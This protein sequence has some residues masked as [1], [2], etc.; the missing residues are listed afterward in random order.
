MIKN[1]LKLLLLLSLPVGVFAQGLAHTRVDQTVGASCVGPALGLQYNVDNG[2]IF[3][4]VN[5]G[6][7]ASPVFQWAQ[8]P[9]QGNTQ[10]F[11]GTA[12]PGSVSGN[13][14]GAL[15]SDTTNHNAYVCNA[16]SGTAAPACTAVGAGNWLLLNSG[17]GALEV[18]LAGTAQGTRGKLNFT[19]TGTG[20]TQSCVDNSG[21]SRVDCS[22]SVDPA[23]TATVTSLAQGDLT[24][25]ISS[26]GTPA[27]VG[28][29]A[30]GC[31]AMVLKTG[32]TITL[33]VD[34]TNI[35]G[36]AS[37]N[38][39]STSAV[40][41]KTRA[42]ADPYPNV[43][44][45]NIGFTLYYNGVNWILPD[46]IAYGVPPEPWVVGTGGVIANTLVILDSSN[47]AK[48]IAATG[49]GAYGVAVS[50]V[51]A[52]G[53]V[54]VRRY[55][56]ASLIADTGGVTASHLIGA[57]TSTV[58]DGVDLAQTASS[59]V[60]MATRI[61]GTALTTATAGNPFYVSLTPAH[62]GTQIASAFSTLTDGATVTWAIGNSSAANQTLTFTTHG[63]SRTLNITN[64]VSGGN[65]VLKIIQD[66]TGVEGLT[67]GTGC[68]WKVIGGGAGAITTSTG[69]NAVDILAFTYDGAT[70]YATFGK[71]YN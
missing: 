48:V 18:D 58:I 11:F 30:A 3:A 39:C 5:N 27:Y 35:S 71:N 10:E 16:A 40:N 14:P 4:C 59:S 2:H 67:L 21:A 54:Y 24:T 61:I 68:T 41:I 51:S 9:T 38:L 44:P 28:S 46:W 26:N 47:P 60:S 43:I 7:D 1:V 53:V 64:P 33:K 63:G 56:I 49:G 31:S 37:L 34:V 70:C 23:Y 57:G 25:A 12:A 29:P 20:I 55:G 19:N 8:I 50:T 13:L 62:Y 66:G 52:A 36:T 45:I 42:G 65:Y 17:G 22:T 32:M 15:F 6:T 69:A